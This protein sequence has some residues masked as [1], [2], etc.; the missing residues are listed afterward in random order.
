MNTPLVIYQHDLTSFPKLLQMAT[1]IR[2]DDVED[3]NDDDIGIE[4]NK[5]VPFEDEPAL[6]WIKLQQMAF[7]IRHCIILLNYEY[8]YL[9]Y[10][11][12]NLILKHKLHMVAI[13]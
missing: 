11:F 8:I 3:F 13:R 6:G 10:F 7:F 5:Q 2:E 4:M 1:A 12:L 9:R